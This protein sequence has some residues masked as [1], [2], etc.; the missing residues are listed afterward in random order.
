MSMTAA[1]LA[2]QLS[3]GPAAAAELALRLSVSQATI[4]RAVRKLERNGQVVRLLGTTRGARYGLCRA[5]GGIGSR[6]PLYRI[7]TQGSPRQI[8]TLHA[9][10]P[11][12]HYV[13]E[14]PGRIPGLFEGLPYYLQDLRPTGFLGRAIPAAYP[15]LTL[16]ARVSDWTDAH[17]LTYL[18]RRGSQNIGDLILGTESLDDYLTGAH[19]PR[20][21]TLIDREQAYPAASQSAMLSEPPGSSA[22]GE[23]PKFSARLID[24]H[25]DAAREVVRHVLVK[26]SPPRITPQ[27]VRWADLLIAEHLA[28]QTLEDHGIDV[29]R[30]EL[31]ECGD[32]VFLE[33]ER[34]DRTGARGRRGVVSLYALDLARYGQ[35]DSW[36]A[37][38]QRLSRDELL[39]SEDAQHITLLD[40]FGALIA[41]TDR[42]FGNI[43][44]FDDYEGPLRLAP[45]YDMLPMLFAP[46]S[47]QIIERRF[48]PPGP[49]A[50]SL[51]VWSRARDL[52][53]TFWGRLS[54]D[55]RISSEFRETGGRCFDAVRAI[56]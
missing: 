26:F 19:G 40:T 15:E 18:A 48:Q 39:S 56:R 6:W 14:G 11:N 7:D 5:V 32:Q 47:E 35:L 29:A 38:A 36:S 24:T 16:P 21:V 28:L 49:S 55:T 10:E 4:S 53:E 37:C 34:F 12:H 30:S 50:T 51:P 52:A 42:H 45:V 23:H 9:I 54:Q 43:T 8:A 27:G 1:L 3:Q 31:L 17:T 46:R 33:S 13:A 44:L 20:S 25:T 22:Q 2:E 41:N